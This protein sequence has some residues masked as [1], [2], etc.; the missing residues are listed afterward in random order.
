M[1]IRL[2]PDALVNQ[3]AAGEVVSR[4]SSVVKELVE[5]SIDSGADQI[6]IYT[7]GGGARLIRVIDN[8]SGI[9]REELLLALTRHATSKIGSLDDLDRVRSLGFRGEALP[10]IASVSRM[11]LSS[12]R[13]IDEVGSK[14][15]V[16]HGNSRELELCRRAPGTEVEV[17]DLFYSVPARRKFLRSERSENSQIED[18]LRT[19]ALSRPE[20]RLLWERDG[21]RVFDFDASESDPI[22]RAAS[23]FGKDDIRSSLVLDSE[24]AGLRLHGWVGLPA[25]ARGQPDRQYFYVNDRPV[26]DRVVA[27]AVRQAFSDVLFHGRHPVFVLHLELDPSEVDVN[28]HPAKSEVRFRQTRAVHD[29]IFRSLH[30]ALAS[31]MPGR[32]TPLAEPGGMTVGA[33]ARWPTRS[34]PIPFPVAESPANW[35]GLYGPRGSQDPAGQYSGAGGG[36][37]PFSLPRPAAIPLAPDATAEM[38]PLGRAIAQLHGIFILSENAR[39]LVVVDMHA[40][41]E[42]VLFEQLKAQRDSG[43]I[44]LQRLLVSVQ[45]TV[46]VAEADAA[47]RWQG[48]IRE[49]GIELVRSGPSSVAV[50]GVASQLERGDTE[51]LVSDLLAELASSEGDVHWLTRRQDALLANVACRAAVHAHR[52]LEIAEMD[53]LLRAMERTQRADQC[54]HGRPTW[55]QLDLEQMDRF[56]LRGR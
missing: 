38:P 20:L 30:G 50:H 54:N 46:S 21:S 18:A 17:R 1:T 41:H 55:I 3:I 12:K 44:P 27:H 2:L 51:R 22:R 9:A 5:N 35:G 42:R 11:T 8:G 56:F 6:E 47:E 7:E 31:T 4:P 40:A 33:D 19:I 39:G 28:V 26:R 14:I 48:A 53:A 36:E 52:R 43:S 34:A 32:E 49:A 23:V 25:M 10:S 16:D 15:V 45:I 37:D 29:F 13:E 24:A